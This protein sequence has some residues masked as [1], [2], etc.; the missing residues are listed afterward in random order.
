MPPD[1][2]NGVQGTASA[3]ALGTYHSLALSSVPEPPHWMLLGTR[4]G[5]LT[6]LRRIWWVTR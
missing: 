2:V 6:L 3:I 1:S 5:T 4:L